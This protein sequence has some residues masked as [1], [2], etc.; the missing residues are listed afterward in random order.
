MLYLVLLPQA[1]S[2]LLDSD[3]MLAFNNSSTG[4]SLNL[5]TGTTSDKV[6]V[7]IKK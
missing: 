6:D 2:L 4:Y 3:D 5:G 1:S 7:L